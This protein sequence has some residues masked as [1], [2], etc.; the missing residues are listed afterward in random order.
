[1]FIWYGINRMDI[2]VIKT[3]FDI[4]TLPKVNKSREAP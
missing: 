1:M 2:Y 4:I 3:K